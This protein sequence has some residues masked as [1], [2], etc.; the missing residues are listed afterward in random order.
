MVMLGVDEI[1]RLCKIEERQNWHEAE[2]ER[3]HMHIGKLD[4]S[5]NELQERFGDTA[6]H[7][8]ILKLNEKIDSSVNGLL[9]DAL[10]SVPQKTTLI[11]TIIMA[12]IA[13]A[14]ILLPHLK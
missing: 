12:L 7:D 3:A 10:A 2:I 11:F 8:D 5:I 13:A 6:T 1:G 4:K 9:R 14:G